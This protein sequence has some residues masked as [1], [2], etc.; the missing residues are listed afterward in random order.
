MTVNNI[1]YHNKL[2]NAMSTVFTIIVTP[3][4]DKKKKPVQQ[5]HVTLQSN[6]V[7][8]KSLIPQTFS[9]VPRTFYFNN[10]KISCLTQT[11]LW[12]TRSFNL[13]Y[14]R[15]QLKSVCNYNT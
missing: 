7:N 2:I 13:T 11:C 4:K 6:L 10:V 14:H 12:I 8:S 5:A 15:Y 9:P 1:K 3:R